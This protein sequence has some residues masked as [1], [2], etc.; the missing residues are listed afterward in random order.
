[1]S[2]EITSSS[3][4]TQVSKFSSCCIIFSVA[5][6]YVIVGGVE[7]DFDAVKS[8]FW[9]PS[10][11]EALFIVHSRTGFD[12]SGDI[13]GS[14]PMLKARGNLGTAFSRDLLYVIFDGCERNIAMYA[15]M[16]FRSRCQVYDRK[17]AAKFYRVKRHDTTNRTCSVW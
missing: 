16:L 12:I 4:C 14:C 17:S 11:F 9:R 13:C 3:F 6:I 2:V 5:W 10:E 1:M 7:G 8:H 15:A